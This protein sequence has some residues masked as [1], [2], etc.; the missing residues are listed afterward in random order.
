MITSQPVI[1]TAVP[2]DDLKVMEATNFSLTGGVVNVPDETIVEHIKAAIRL[3]YPQARLDAP[4]SDH[5]VIAGS[6]PSLNAHEKQ[7][8][9]LMHKG[10]KLV[11]LNGAYQW[12]IERNLRPSTTIVMDARASNARFLDPAIPHCRY[13]I[14]S[15]CH[16]DTWAAVAG[17]PNVWIFHAAGPDSAVKEVLDE[18][19]L[20]NW[21]GVIGGTTVFTRGLMLLRMLGYL[22]FDAFGIDSC[23]MGEEHHAFRQEENDKDT[24]YRVKVDAPNGASRVFTCSAWHLKQAEDFLQTIKINGHHFLLNMHGNGMLAFMLNHAAT[25]AV[26]EAQET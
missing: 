12:A 15:Q 18:Y 9:Q 25:R 17:R 3:G 10:A 21:H 7:I 6:G 22:R 1:G 24:R 8:A 2:E 23:W 26:I 16:P 14:A 4:K 20:G 13:L 5:L 11:T 19:Y